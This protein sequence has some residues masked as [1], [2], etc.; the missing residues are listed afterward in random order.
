VVVDVVFCGRLLKT[1]FGEA[2]VAVLDDELAV[3]VPVVDEF[4]V[5][6]L[7]ALL[8]ADRAVPVVGLAAAVLLR[9]APAPPAAPAPP[10]DC[11]T[12]VAQKQVAISAMDTAVATRVRRDRMAVTPRC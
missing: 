9:V 8:V 11:A 3:P 2:V 12:A 10:V 5:V 4:A 7:V 1:R 6:E